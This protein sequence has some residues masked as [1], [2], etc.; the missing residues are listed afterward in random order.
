MAS[1]VDAPTALVQWPQR[2]A[3][4]GIWFRHS[5][6]GRVAEGVAVPGLLIRVAIAFVGTTTEE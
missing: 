2:R 3:R 1:Y 4:M 6:Q 5:G